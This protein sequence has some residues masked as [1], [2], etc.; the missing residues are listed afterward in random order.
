M[1]PAMNYLT[2]AWEGVCTAGRHSWAEVNGGMYA[3]LNT[4]IGC[5]M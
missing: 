2:A 4:A 5:E 3:S 1:S